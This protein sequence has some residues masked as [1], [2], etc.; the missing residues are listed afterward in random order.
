M[1]MNV[2]VLLL[3]MTI[4]KKVRKN[5]VIGNK[6]DNYSKDDFINDLRNIIQMPILCFFLIF[7]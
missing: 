1:V 6:K 7:L 5:R 3:K 4:R 2:N